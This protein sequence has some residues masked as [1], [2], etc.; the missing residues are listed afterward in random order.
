MIV[1]LSI[2]TRKQILMKLFSSWLE[3][4]NSRQPGGFFQ[5]FPTL[6]LARYCFYIKSSKHQYNE[7]FKGR[8][9][10][11][12]G[13]SAVLRIADQFDPF[14]NE[15]Y[16]D[17]RSTYFSDILALYQTGYLH[18]TGKPSPP[19]PQPSYVCFS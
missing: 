8:L 17:R 14:L 2:S 10:R 11:T 1:N 12:E 3:G 5:N 9:A 4:R 15:Y 19:L 6:N 16:F 7:L 13:S 18:M